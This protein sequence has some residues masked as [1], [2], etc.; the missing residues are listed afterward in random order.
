MGH[1]DKAGRRL[2]GFEGAFD[3]LCSVGKCVCICAVCHTLQ[4]AS[5]CKFYSYSA[6]VV[7]AVDS[8]M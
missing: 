1:H 2:C 7:A 8:A 3:G 5:T 6:P 4:G